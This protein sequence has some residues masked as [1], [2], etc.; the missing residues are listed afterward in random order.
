MYQGLI[1]LNPAIQKAPLI[2]GN[3]W[4]AGLRHLIDYKPATKPIRF[5]LLI[6]FSG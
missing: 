4:N 6:A 1:P 5:E 3:R 2:K